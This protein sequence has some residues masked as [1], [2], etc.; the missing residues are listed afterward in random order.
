MFLDQRHQAF[1][2]HGFVGGAQFVQRPPS[3]LDDDLTFDLCPADGVDIETVD[4]N[5]EVVLVVDD[6]RA[7]E[8]E[9]DLTSCHD[10]PELEQLQAGLFANLAASCVGD[11]LTILHTATWWEPPPSG[12]GIRRITTTKQQYG[13]ILGY[14]NN[15]RCMPHRTLVS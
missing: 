15:L 10:R 4:A 13:L 12:A 3:G 6:N 11:G 9:L 14:E 1:G 8:E 7:V 2:V 5:D